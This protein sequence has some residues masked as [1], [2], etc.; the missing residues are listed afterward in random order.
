MRKFAM[1]SLSTKVGEIISK[2]LQHTTPFVYHKCGK[3]LFWQRDLNIQYNPCWWQKAWLLVSIYGFQSMTSSWGYVKNYEYIRHHGKRLSFLHSVVGGFV[4]HACDTYLIPCES[5]E[6]S[7]GL[8]EK[9]GRFSVMHP[10]CF[11]V[12]KS[13]PRANISW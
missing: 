5:V 13:C 11:S 7:T 8:F 2:S 6:N 1:T 3:R 4:I 9:A 12:T 10:T